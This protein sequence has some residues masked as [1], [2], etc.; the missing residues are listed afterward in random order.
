MAFYDNEEDIE[1]AELYRLFASLFMNE[2]SD[3]MII[4]VKEMFQMKSSES[5][6]QIRMD[7]ANIFL[8]PDLHMAPYE[9]LYNYPLGDRPR[10][11]GKAAEEVQLFYIAAGL[12]VDEEINIMPDHISAE[13]IFMSYLIENGR[14]DLQMR[15]LDDHLAKWIPEYCDEVSR[16]AGTTFY[17]EIAN[18]LKEFILSEVEAKKDRGPQKI[19]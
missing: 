19:L 3:E 11:P 1:R 2:P 16:H 13:L 8:R 15:F 12:I 6:P 10:L 7:F 9:S 4:Q 5:P 14:S 17:K 18:I